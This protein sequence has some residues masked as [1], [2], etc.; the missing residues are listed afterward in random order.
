MLLERPLDNPFKKAYVE[1]GGVDSMDKL[2]PAGHYVSMNGQEVYKFAIKRV[3]E[4]IHQILDKTGYAAEDVDYYVL[5]QANLRILASVSKRIGVPIEKF[6]VNLDE[7]GNTSAG[8]VPLALADMDRK[9]MLKK[10]T[11]IMMVGFGG[12]LTWGGGLVII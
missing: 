12:G 7:Y 2:P 10:G 4:C 11:K 5:H 3:P 1:N 6:Y 8:S 9:G